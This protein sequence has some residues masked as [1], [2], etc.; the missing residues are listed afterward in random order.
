ML[1]FALFLMSPGLMAQ[2]NF[3]FP[4]WSGDAPGAL[5]QA[6]KDIP[7]MTVFLPSPEK[8]TG[9]AMVIFPGGGYAGLA[10]HEG[11]QYARWFNELG[12]AG[13]VVKYRLGSVG[14]RHP[15]MLQDAAR[16]VRTAR[17]RAEEWKLDP[18][19]IGVI[20]SSAG[21]HL[22]ST[23]MT[24]WDRG[25]PTAANA[26]ERQSSRPDLVI[27]C[28]PVVSMSQPFTHRGSR[29]NLLGDHPSPELQRELS[30]ELQ[31][32]TNTPPCFIWST[33]DDRTVPVENSL[34]LALALSKVRVPF[35]LHIYAHG[36]HGIGLGNKTF[37]QSKFHP[38]TRECELWLRQNHF[39]K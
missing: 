20:G 27:L 35:D 36:P 13:L 21:G 7:T 32:S 30:A 38:W 5:G 34:T 14:Y 31:V 39:T 2:T 6:A 29:A 10:D 33:A 23:L 24:H 8:A 16:A 18:Q 37:D 9:A 26:I 28:Y 22:A 12:L 11:S 4:L 3:S 1:T 17:A 15:A 19:R 25:N